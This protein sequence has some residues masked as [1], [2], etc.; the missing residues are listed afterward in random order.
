MSKVKYIVLHLSLKLSQLNLQDFLQKEEYKTLEYNLTTTGL[1]LDKVT[2]F[3][4]EV[5]LQFDYCC[6][7]PYHNLGRLTVLTE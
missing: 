6:M 2:A 4:D 3:W 1:E 7:T 5:I